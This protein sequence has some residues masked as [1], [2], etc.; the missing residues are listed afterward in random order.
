MAKTTKGDNCWNCGHRL[1]QPHQ[2]RGPERCGCGA[3]NCVVCP[4]CGQPLCAYA[5]SD[6]ARADKR[7]KA[8]KIKGMAKATVQGLDRSGGSGG[9]AKVR[10]A[11]LPAVDLFPL[12]VFPAA[13][14]DYVNE[15]ARAFGCPPDYVGVSILAVAAAIGDSRAIEA[16]Q[17]YRVSPSLYAAIVGPPGSTK[18]PVFSFVSRPVDE[19]QEQLLRAYRKEWAAYQ[20]AQDSF[21]RE[22]RET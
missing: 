14:Q 3:G 5:K 20:V 22:Q 15:T 17:T 1:D 19:R 18:S 7:A 10:Q 4:K 2:G 21:E 13:L 12:A 6:Q 8:E 11:H 9:T 16:K